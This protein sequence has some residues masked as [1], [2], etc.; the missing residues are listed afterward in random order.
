MKK[1]IYLILLFI[2]PFLSFGQFSESLKEMELDKNADFKKYQSLVFDATNF[3]LKNPVDVKSKEFISATRIMEFWMNKET[4][5]RIPTFGNFF[6]S[7]TNKNKQQ[8]LYTVAMINYVLDQK[9]NHQRILKCIKIKGQK[10][11]EQEDVREVQLEGGRILLK[12]IGNR[13]NH[14]PMNSKTRRYW[15]AY[16]KNQLNEIFFKK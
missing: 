5:M 6:S 1:K 3:I 13:K 11:K 8:F 12:Y 14:V 15:K 9:I 16:K 10:Y 2:I 4:G 7:L